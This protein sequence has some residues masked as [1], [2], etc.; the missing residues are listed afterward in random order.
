M[1]VLYSVLAGVGGGASQRGLARQDALRVEPVDG[2]YFSGGGVVTLDLAYFVHFRV[3]QPI[4]I[5]AMEYLCSVAAGNVDLALLS[6]TDFATLTR[7]G[8]TGA[9][10]AAGSN[11]IHSI[12][13]TAPVAIVP[14]VDYF[15]S[16]VGSSGTLQIARAAQFA[17]I[18]GA[19]KTLFQKAA[20]NPI[21]SSVATLASG[22][23]V[24]W[25][26]LKAA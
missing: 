5:A 26:C 13:L 21:P 19:N 7:L 11:A 20:T 2:R 24:P 16:I 15:A 3:D 1:S 17:G 23:M 6:T 10:A 14:G 4:T 25:L 18:S 8:S 22:T 12:A 9:T